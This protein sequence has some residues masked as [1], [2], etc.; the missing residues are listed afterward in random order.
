MENCFENN[1]DEYAKG[2][3]DT[4]VNKHRE[5]Q[6]QKKKTFE[7]FYSFYYYII[8]FPGVLY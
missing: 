4:H 5:Q 7:T 2:R 8:I 3:K 1:E 6:Q